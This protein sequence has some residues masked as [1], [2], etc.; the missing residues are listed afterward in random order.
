MPYRPAAAPRRSDI[1][2]VTLTTRDGLSLHGQLHRGGR[3][4]AVL[5][6]HP[7]TLNGGTMGAGLVPVLADA[8]ARAGFTVLR[9]DFRG[10]GSS[11]GSFG[12]GTGELLDVDAAVAYL[13]EAAPDLPLVLV[14]WS[15][16]AAVSLRWLVD[17]GDA[18]GWLGIAVALGMEEL[19]V[20]KVSADELRGLTVP[21]SFVHG[22]DDD[23]APL[24]RVRAL[25]ILTDH[26]ELH[27]IDGGSHFLQG[28]VTEVTDLTAAFVARVAAP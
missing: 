25:T 5:L 4:G 13:R 22:T 18:D 15:F 2:D 27:P 10:A 19:G 7:H 12:H 17:R 6:C 26:A 3:R 24:Y 23:V 20:P 1:G 14:G 9:F 8:L 16:G 11:E 21:L 28:H